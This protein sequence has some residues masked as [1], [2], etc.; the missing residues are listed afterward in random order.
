MLAR[1]A[2]RTARLDLLDL[3]TGTGC[4]LLA[5]LS[6]FPAA[7]GIGV[8]VSAGAAATARGNAAALGLAGRA[9]FLVGEWG[10]ALSAR[11]T[12]IV[13]NPP[14][15]ATPALA[16]LPLEVRRHDPPRA[17]DGGADG[18]DAYRR[19]A[20]G[21]PALLMPGGL[22]A[23]EI[24]AG[25]AV[26]VAAILQARGLVIAGIERDLAGIERCVVARLGRG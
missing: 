19:I 23:T 25:Q 9:R 13:A 2:E 4:L 17:L 22:F 12:A 21:L 16:A 5:L 14:Y 7:F 15:I 18:L 1:L 20:A 26:A 11:F 8:D 3:G 6:E 10:A 24:G